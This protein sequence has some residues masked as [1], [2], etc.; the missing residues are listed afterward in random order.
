M[1]HCMNVTFV[2]YIKEK[3][4]VGMLNEGRIIFDVSGKN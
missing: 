2:T 1:L 3:Y 4:V